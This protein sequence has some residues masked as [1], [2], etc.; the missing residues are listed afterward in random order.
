MFFNNFTCHFQQMNW[1]IFSLNDI[2]HAV[3]H[4]ETMC[5]TNGPGTVAAVMFKTNQAVSVLKTHM[6]CNL[7]KL[8]ILFKR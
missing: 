5:K 1:W 4:L 2:L 3:F 7:D 6:A 8:N